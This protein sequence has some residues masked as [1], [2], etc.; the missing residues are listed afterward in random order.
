MNISAAVAAQ[1][2]YA[3]LVIR[4]CVIIR[5]DAVTGRRGRPPAS[6]R[7]R[8]AAPVAMVGI[9]PLAVLA[10]RGQ[11]PEVALVAVYLPVIT[12]VGF[13]AASG[14]VRRRE[15]AADSRHRQLN[16][17]EVRRWL[18]RPAPV[19]VLTGTVGTAS[20]FAVLVAAEG[21][22]PWFEARFATLTPSSTA[23]QAAA[24]A[25][26]TM[27]ATIVLLAV[28]LGL[29]VAQL[30]PCSYSGGGSAGRSLTRT[31]GSPPPTGPSLRGRRLRVVRGQSQDGPVPESAACSA[32]LPRG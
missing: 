28:V 22:S 16:G 17:L 20:P 12:A 11:S 23:Q 6:D 13:A 19:A 31:T 29:L 21:L 27:V 2:L 5:R 1:V 32:R 25:T 3:F 24:V 9:F 18:W 26:A 14:V 7:L 15:H 8:T 10:V 30:S 4:T